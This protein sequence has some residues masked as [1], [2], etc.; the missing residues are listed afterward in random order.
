[1][2]LKSLLKDDLF[3]WK[4][5]NHMELRVVVKC[6]LNILKLTGHVDVFDVFAVFDIFRCF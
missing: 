3:A 2:L 1:M 6:S 5:Y 4:A